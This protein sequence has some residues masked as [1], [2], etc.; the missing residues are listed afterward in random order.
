MNDIK[1]QPIIKQEVQVKQEAVQVRN[2]EVVVDKTETKVQVKK[3]A[4]QN[5]DSTPDPK[6]SPNSDEDRLLDDEIFG[7][8]PKRP[9]IV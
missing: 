8:I 6:V 7:T 4:V 2:E 1:K 9:K 3:E 5:V